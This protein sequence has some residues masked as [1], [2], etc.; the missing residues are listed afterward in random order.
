MLGPPNR[1]SH[2]ARKLT[3][4]G[5]FLCKPLRQLSDAP[6]SFVRNL[7]WPAAALPI[8]V[9]AAR[10]DRVVQLPSTHLPTQRDHVVVP[11][12][13]T[14]MLLRRDVA[15]YVA[16]F[17]REGQFGSAPQPGSPSRE[18]GGTATNQA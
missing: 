1:G 2:V 9:I 11:S 7:P 18:P 17:L 12:G 5:G 10:H 3:K 6:D 8:G 16:R 13:H 14:R 15:T 4:W